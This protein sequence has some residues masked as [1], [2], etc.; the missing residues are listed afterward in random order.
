MHTLSPDTHPKVEQLHIELLRNAPV[1]KRLQMVNSMVKA[2]WRL[3]WQGICERYP[4]ESLGARI[5]R[6]MLLLYNDKVIAKKIAD[7]FREKGITGQ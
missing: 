3:S 2:T 5:E 7:S 1:W 6:F 4:D